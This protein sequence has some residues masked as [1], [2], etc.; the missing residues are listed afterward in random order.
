[1]K[2]KLVLIASFGLG[3]FSAFAAE[4]SVEVYCLDKATSKSYGTSG[5]SI[6]VLENAL[7]KVAPE[8]G[9]NAAGEVI[10]LKKGECKIQLVALPDPFEG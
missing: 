4:Y 3:S 5:T 10:D 6:Q 1:M 2:T 9:S 8:P 7:I